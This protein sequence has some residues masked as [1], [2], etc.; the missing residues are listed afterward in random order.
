MRWEQE[1]GKFRESLVFGKGERGM[2]R[3][4]GSVAW[5]CN[6]FAGTK[7]WF[8]KRVKGRH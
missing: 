5:F 2:G 3:K 4:E 7:V 6:A 8:G 1:L